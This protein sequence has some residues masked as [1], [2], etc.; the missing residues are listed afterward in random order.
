MVY[1]RVCPSEEKKN[2]WDFSQRFELKV[3]PFGYTPGG[4]KPIKTSAS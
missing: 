3:I 4:H 1:N 2:R